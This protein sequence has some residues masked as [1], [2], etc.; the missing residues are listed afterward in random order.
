MEQWLVGA[1]RDRARATA[2][3]LAGIWQDVCAEL[4]N[5]V[6]LEARVLSSLRATRPLAI[7][8]GV[9][10]LEAPDRH[11]RDMVEI[12]LREAVEKVL[13]RRLRYPVQIAITVA[14][15]AEDFSR[16]ARS[17]AMTSTPATSA[18]ATSAPATAAAVDAAVA[19]AAAAV[20][21]RRQPDLTAAYAELI[22]QP[23]VA[24][25]LAEVLVAA[26]QLGPS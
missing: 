26:G 14:G 20:A 15:A 5:P 11:A 8:E 19:A 24:R 25:R 18:P 4:D 16:A 17:A 22:A 2:T 6:L 21:R 23:D 10:L 3:D 13:S 7:V 1:G 9:L 12:R